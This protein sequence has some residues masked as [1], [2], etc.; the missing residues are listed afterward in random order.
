MMRYQKKRRM[1]RQKTTIL[2]IGI[3]IVACAGIVLKFGIVSAADNNAKTSITTASA[4][5]VTFT[6]GIN[7]V[8]ASTDVPNDQKVI[9]LQAY[10][11]QV[12]T[13]ADTICRDQRSTIYYDV[14]PIHNTCEKAHSQLVDIGTS[15]AAIYSYITDEIVL[16]ALLPKGSTSNGLSDTYDLWNRTSSLLSAA[17]VGEEANNIKSSLQKAVDGYRDAWKSLVDAN[18]KQDSSGFNAAKTAVQAAYSSLQSQKDVSITQ[19]DALDTLFTSK[20]SAFISTTK[21]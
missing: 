17:K 2:V 15:S 19:L 14:L 6:T 21:G 7:G 11:S 4:N 10:V 18:S 3:I 13:L 20:Y 12:K 1:S 16:S 8:I 5:L 9:K